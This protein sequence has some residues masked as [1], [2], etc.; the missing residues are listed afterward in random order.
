MP[1]AYDC[2]RHHRQADRGSDKDQLQSSVDLGDLGG[3]H[4]SRGKGEIPIASHRLWR[5]QGDPAIVDSRDS[6]TNIATED[7]DGQPHY[8]HVRNES[9]RR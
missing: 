4:L 6:Q 3:L 8:K 2:L 1:R 5:R 9:K 7:D